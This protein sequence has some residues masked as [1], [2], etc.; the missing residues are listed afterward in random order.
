M[1]F[2]GLRG[3]GRGNR[4]ER[5]SLAGGREPKKFTSSKPM[6]KGQ[7]RVQYRF[8]RTIR[9]GRKTRPAT[10]GRSV[11]RGKL[12]KPE[13]HRQHQT[14]FPSGATPSPGEGLHANPWREPKKRVDIGLNSSYEE[15]EKG[16]ARYL[17]R[18]A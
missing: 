17:P 1:A 12:V 18:D 5:R 13:H 10:G 7:E 16:R 6:E 15:G 3:G 14:R 9:N 8:A 2:H 11:E 4:L